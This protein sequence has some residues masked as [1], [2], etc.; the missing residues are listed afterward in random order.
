[1]LYSRPELPDN[2]AGEDR[3]T[4]LDL[5]SL[6]QDNEERD[7]NQTSVEFLDLTLNIINGTIETSLFRKP[8]AT[9][10]L[11]EFSSFHPTHLKRGIPYGQY[12]RLRRNCTDIQ[13]FKQN[14]L[15]LTARFRNRGYPKKLLNQAYNKALHMDR[16]TLLTP[17]HRQ[18]NR[19][20]R[21]DY[22]AAQTESAETSINHISGSKRQI[23]TQKADFS[24][25]TF[26]GLSRRSLL[27]WSSPYP[28]FLSG[29]LLFTITHWFGLSTARNDT[30]RTHLSRWHTGLDHSDMKVL[31]I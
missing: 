20:L 26:L 15:D 7:S 30:I 10:S 2:V 9:N 4:F 3:Q 18:E 23:T 14:A 5:L 1:M 11:L 12:L 19:E 31:K 27:H 25:R 13:D 6:L 17:R 21:T 8:T 16:Q 29:S 24:G 28:A 22:S